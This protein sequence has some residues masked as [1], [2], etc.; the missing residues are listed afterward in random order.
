M[1]KVFI[2]ASLLFSSLA[3]AQLPVLPISSDGEFISVIT[4]PAGCVADASGTPIASGTFQ[5]QGVDGTGTSPIPFGTGSHQSLT[6]PVVRIITAGSL[7]TALQIANPANTSP[8]NVLYHIVIQDNYTHK[9][10][11]YPGVPIYLNDVPVSGRFTAFN[12]CKMN[13]GLA[14]TSVPVT[15]IQGPQGPPGAPGSGTGG[16]SLL[17]C[18]MSGPL[19]AVKPT[20]TSDPSSVATMGLLRESTGRSVLEW[21][22]TCNG[23]AD[24]HD[25]FQNALTWAH[26]N[27]TCI[28]FPAKTC[29]LATPVS[30]NGECMRGMGEDNSIIKGGN[31]YDVFQT[32]DQHAA[33]VPFLTGQHIS[34]FTV[35]VDDTTS[36][37]VWGSFSSRGAGYH[38]IFAPSQ[39]AAST[40]PA[41]QVGNAAFSFPSA[42]VPNTGPNATVFER[43]KI[44]NNGPHHQNGSAGFFFQSLPYNVT[45]RDLHILNTE[46]GIVEALNS[47]SSSWPSFFAS[48]WSSDTNLIDNVNITSA[49]NLVL[50]GRTNWTM[51]GLNIYSRGKY[52]TSGC[53]D[54]HSTGLAFTTDMFH[55]DIINPY[56]EPGCLDAGATLTADINA[57]VT[58][59]P[60]SFVGQLSTHGGTLLISSSA[61]AQGEIINYTGISGLTLTGVTRGAM[62]TT[63]IAHVGT[64]SSP[65]TISY[66]FDEI[67]GSMLHF[68]TGSIK[69]G[70]GAWVA[71][72]AN[73]ST[74][75]DVG[76]VGTNPHY[77]A[78]E[79]FGSRNKIQTFSANESDVFDWG[80][81]NVTTSVDP[82]GYY[83]STATERVIEQFPA[84]MAIANKLTVDSIATNSDFFQSLDDLFFTPDRLITPSGIGGGFGSNVPVVLDATA[85]VSQHYVYVPSGTNILADR[86]NGTPSYLV[87]GKL[88]PSKVITHLWTKGDTTATI[89]VGMP[90]AS[91]YVGRTG[92]CTVLTTWSECKIAM[93]LS[94]I[95]LGGSTRIDI[96]SASTGVKYAAIAILPV[97]GT[98]PD[99]L[100]SAT[101]NVALRPELDFGAKINAA[102]AAYPTS[103]LFI[104]ALP[105]TTSL[106]DCYQFSTPIV[107]NTPVKLTSGTTGTACLQYTGTSG[108]AYTCNAAA[109]NTGCSMDGVKI[110]S[111]GTANTA[112]GILIAG[113]QFSC[114]DSSVGGY[115]FSGSGAYGFNTGVSFGNN[116][117]L[118]DLNNCKLSENALDF[119][120]PGGLTNSG[121]NIRII[122]GVLSGVSSLSTTATCVSIG[123]ATSSGPDM[124]WVAPSFDRC[125][126]S[127]ANSSV[128]LISPHFEDN[129]A[130]S[131]PFLTVNASA[132]YGNGTWGPQVVLDAPYFM[133]DTGP[134][135]ASLIECDRFC[136]LTLNSISDYAASI[137]LVNMNGGAGTQSL[138][139]NSPASIRT[140]AQLF[141][142]ASGGAANLNINT[143]AVQISMAAGN[144]VLATS[145]FTGDNMKTA[146][147]VADANK[148]NMY[149]WTGTGPNLWGFGIKNNA[150]ALDFCTISAFAGTTYSAL[151]TETSICNAHL[152]AAGIFQ[153]SGDPTNANDVANK[154]YVDTHSSSG[155]CTNCVTSP[156]TVPSAGVAHFGGTSLDL[157]PQPVNLATEVT[158]IMSVSHVGGIG[159]ASGI[160]PL[161]SGSKVPV[162]NLPAGSFGTT[163]FGKN[164]VTDFSMVTTASVD[165]ST[166]LTNAINAVNAN[167]SPELFVPCGNYYFSTGVNIVGSTNLNIQGEGTPG[168]ASQGCVTFYSDQPIVILTLNGGTTS[169]NNL[170]G[171]HVHNIA[172]QDSSA[173]HN[174][175][176][177]GLHVLNYANIDLDV[178]MF[179]IQGAELTAG[180]VSI[181]TGSRSVTG[182]GTSW[183]ASSNPKVLWVNGLPYEMLVTSS[184]TGTLSAMNFLKASVSGVNYAL[185]GGLG[186]WLDPGTNF[187]QYGK[188]V[189]NSHLTRYPLF[190]SSGASGAFGVSR[191]DIT[192]GFQNC[193]AY[194]ISD[195][196]AIYL[197]Q[198]SDTDWIATSANN[199]LMEIVIAGGHQNDVAHS[200]FENTGT[201]FP[202]STTCPAQVAASG[203]AQKSCSKGV[204]VTGDT[205]N[206]TFGNRI[207]DTY[208]LGHG[209]AIELDT[210]AWQARF[211]GNTLRANVNDFLD[212]GTANTGE[213]NGTLYFLNHITKTVASGAPSGACVTGSEYTNS[214]GTTGSLEYRCRAAAWV[215]TY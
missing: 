140:E 125:A 211:G 76:I 171:P 175:V 19:I 70:G 179:D 143:S 93:D 122:G 50:L 181:A 167:G 113:A 152:T 114:H 205:L 162:A 47:D 12:F 116:A 30:W 109:F 28:V 173:G 16:C 26:A 31:G 164:T 200:R 178:N 142:L 10:T 127:I 134:T 192:G 210:Y 96:P 42:G 103:P 201:N 189:L 146:M 51:R 145:G 83:E 63:A 2:C 94:A 212:A 101:V 22:A 117:Y 59:I 163:Q 92:S 25:A 15:I 207:E 29:Y 84:R 24:D 111:T 39:D 136:A 159:S 17:G 74:M 71:W 176:I 23:I 72:G 67:N 131:Q 182:V 80:N 187:L 68:R 35:K 169:Q 160:A 195:T 85:P 150:D 20:N 129:M 158:G 81:K 155:S 190:Q 112:T 121:E 6:T 202:L 69:Q 27:N 141:T 108:V 106:A 45:F 88:L 151:G 132:S 213:I 198:Y 188:V 196:I 110:I 168:Q 49:V 184:T 95:P 137:P 193:Q 172:F 13:T 41:W 55:A 157:T 147:V 91:S 43:L 56:I 73:N 123:T 118:A 209:N 33:S 130:L 97:S 197:G 64:G 183:V 52:Q 128:H 82:S 77:P 7:Q 44:D 34:D 62:G 208:I 119:L 66:P 98:S 61:A 161:D 58:T 65:E 204:Y 120:Y 191:L 165:N 102:N 126:V 78:L 54:G 86:F 203:V 153:Q 32:V 36:S 5:I 107:I 174:Q 100:T 180:T 8:S 57:S 89:T 115:A 18:T 105:L 3:V 138:T 11:N 37:V 75:N 149:T 87:R 156:T 46:F 186:L 144:H 104:P 166:M 60:I 40:L 185:D 194:T 135:T 133:N 53:I 9:I 99:L 177:G 215:N 139:I 170:H 90:Y 21:G 48:N 199:C 214:S 124:T 154:H 1:K 79:I 148:L 38:T 206:N 4:S 14:V